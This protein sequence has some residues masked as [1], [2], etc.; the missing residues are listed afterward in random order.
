MTDTGDRSPS[1]NDGGCSVLVV[2]PHRLRAEIIAELLDSEPGLSASAPT[3]P[4]GAAPSAP[5]PDVVLVDGCSWDERVERVA[6]GWRELYP[7]VSSV[8]LTA[9]GGRADGER[10]AAIGA[11]GWLSAQSAAADLVTGL[12]DCARG[13]RM[14]VRPRAARASGSRTELGW[15]LSELTTREIEIL[16]FVAGGQQSDEVADALGISRHTV[17]THLQNIMAKFGVRS[18]TEMVSVACRAG[19]R[20]GAPT[21]EAP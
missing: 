2:G 4:D 18:R 16:R 3:G 12:R 15:P 11:V 21:E 5:G 14:T 6:S 9:E 19:L 7:A 13:E 1:Y 8:L 10:A 17:R 20:P